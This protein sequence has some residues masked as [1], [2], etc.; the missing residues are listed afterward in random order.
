L[1]IAFDLVPEVSKYGKLKTNAANS[2]ALVF[3]VGL[4]LIIKVVFE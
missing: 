1:R 4:M 2:M 3:G